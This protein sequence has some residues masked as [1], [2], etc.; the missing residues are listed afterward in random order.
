MHDKYISKNYVLKTLTTDNA[1]ETD[2][3]GLFY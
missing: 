3:H 2:I 1:D